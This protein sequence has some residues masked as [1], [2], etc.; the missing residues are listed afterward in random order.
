MSA[1][2]AVIMARRKIHPAKGGLGA[3][4]HALKPP[5]LVRLEEI[6]EEI[7]DHLRPWK[8][9]KGRAAIT[10]EVDRELVFLAILAPLGETY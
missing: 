3:R 2:V 10:A 5:N 7:V 9:R 8:D 1:V 6:V 4:A